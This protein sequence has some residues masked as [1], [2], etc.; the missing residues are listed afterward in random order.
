MFRIIR[1]GVLICAAGL[2]CAQDE[3]PAQAPAG[4]G[5]GRGGLGARRCGG[6]RSAAVRSRDHQGSQDDQGTVH[7][8]PDQERYYYEIPKSELGKDLL[9][10]SQIAKTTVGVGYGGGQLV[11]KVVRWEL[12][13]NRVLLLD[14][15]YSVTADPNEPIAM[16]V[17]NANNESIIQA[18]HVAAFAKD[19]APVIEV[20]PPVHRRP[21][22]IQRPPAAGRHRRGRVALVHRAH[23]PFPENMETEVTV[24]YT[25]TAGGAAAT[26]GGRGGGL[27][28]GHHARQ[29]RH[30]RAASQHGPAAR[31]ADDAAPVRRARRLLHH[32]HD[33]LFAQRVQG[34]AHALH[35]ALAPGKEGS[36]RRDL[37]AG[38]ADRLLHRCGHAEEVGAVAE[39]GH[40]GLE[41]GLRGRRLQER[42]HRQGSADAPRRIPTGAPKTSATP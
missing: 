1:F 40:R 37:R 20:T 8:P 9:W 39:E 35:R 30:R 4:G 23:H 42:H 24:T 17:K 2:L 33:G 21:A 22:G 36:H 29:Q 32:Q 38:E 15:N 27:G 25:R 18:F 3:P 13:G 7:R 5:G 34:R 11:D 41:R 28:G 31:K 6:A 19:G 12:K 14:I 16:A 10:N 26:G